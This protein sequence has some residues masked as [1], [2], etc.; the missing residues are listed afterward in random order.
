MGKAARSLAVLI[1]WLVV[2][3]SCAHQP[4]VEP[5]KTV[6]VADAVPYYCEK[7]GVIQG[8]GGS[9]AYAMANAKERAIERGATHVVLGQPHLDI[10]QG[11][12][13]VVEATLFDC[14]PRGSY[15]PPTGYP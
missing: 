5:G 6:I 10:D 2:G 11:L 3:V 13:T 7:L 9:A 14:P 1:A 8:V 15:F 4:S 12:V